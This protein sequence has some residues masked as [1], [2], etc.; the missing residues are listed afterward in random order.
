MEQ[1]CTGLGY[2]FLEFEPYT[3]KEERKNVAETMVKLGNGDI[4]A[5]EFPRGKFKCNSK[6]YD[7]AAR[8]ET[9]NEKRVKELLNEIEK[10]KGIK[11]DS[12][13]IRYMT[14]LKPYVRFEEL[15]QPIVVS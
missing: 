3:S 5:V 1:A 15:E 8:F 13:S 9:P 4:Q 6:T 2:I 14:A 12:L 10:V 11:K 7:A